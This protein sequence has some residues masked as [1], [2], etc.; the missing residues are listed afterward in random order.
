M[1]DDFSRR[2]LTQSGMRVRTEQDL[3]DDFEDEV[4]M[5]EEESIAYED[6]K[7]A[8]R[9]EMS[10]SIY[11]NRILAIVAVLGLF[12]SIVVFYFTA[13]EADETNKRADAEFQFRTRPYLIIDNIEGNTNLDTTKSDFKVFI[14]NSG[15]I[16][17]RII[18]QAMDCPSSS[19]PLFVPKGDIVGANQSIVYQF[20]L[21]GM[22]EISCNLDIRYGSAIEGFSEKE[23]ETQQKFLYKF[24]EQMHSGGGFMR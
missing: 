15:N 4:A 18:S 12:L 13:H 20:T 2:G 6:E 14:K 5:K 1:R 11:T 21:Q 23:Y 7:D 10:N 9:R 8:H 16:P 24:G 3:K 19:I 22:K 17:A